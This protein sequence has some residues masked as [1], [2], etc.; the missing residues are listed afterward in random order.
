MTDTNYMELA[1]LGLK[2]LNEP[3]DH[4]L[5]SVGNLRVGDTGTLTNDG[6]ALGKCARHAHLRMLGYQIE[7]HGESKLIMFGGGHVSERMWDSW[8]DALGLPYKCEQDIPVE[9]TTTN[10]TKVTGRPDRVFVDKAG[11]PVHFMEHKRVSSIWTAN[12]VLLKGLP[13]FDHLAQAGHYCKLLGVE[14]TLTYTQDVNF[15]FPPNANWA[16]K[17][18]DHPAIKRPGFYCVLEPFIYGYKIRWDGDDL[19]YQGEEQIGWTRSP[20]KWTDIER[21]FEVASAMGPGVDLPPEPHTPTAEGDRGY[22]TW[23]YSPIADVN[24]MVAD[25]QLGYEDWLML[26][27]AR[28][29]TLKLK[30]AAQAGQ[31]SEPVSVSPLER[32]DIN[33]DI[34]EKEKA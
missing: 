19:M 33:V 6:K 20:I 28:P 26:V 22:N 3:S 13:K 7:Q 29:E 15:H 18:L 23:D 31:D 5:L 24:K 9:W 32:S 16:K 17:K 4:E 34:N 2:K 14:G 21:F 30:C 12:S 27:D 11:N 25:K 8:F 10:G 1:R